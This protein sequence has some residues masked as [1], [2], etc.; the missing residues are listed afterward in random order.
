M[1]LKSTLPLITAALFTATTASAVTLE[2]SYYGDTIY[3]DTLAEC[4]YTPQP[5][6]P[7]PGDDDWVWESYHYSYA[8]FS[9]TIILDEAAYGGRFKNSTVVFRH[10]Y[11]YDDTSIETDGVISWNFSVNL[12]TEIAYGTVASFTFGPNYEVLDWNIYAEEDS[13]DSSMDPKWDRIFISEVYYET[14]GDLWA[15]AKEWT[16]RQ[17]PTLGTEIPLPASLPA[18]GA[19]VAALG[20]LRRRRRRA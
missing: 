8:G 11:P 13:P 12:F 9:G 1:H 16:V 10:E 3:Y 17:L 5:A 19:G 20:L 4:T 14:R 15:P 6:G 2:L 7:C 18:L